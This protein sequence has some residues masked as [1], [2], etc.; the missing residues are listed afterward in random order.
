[1]QKDHV[2]WYSHRLGRDMGVAVYGHYGLPVLAFPTSGGEEWELE[3]M[4]LIPALAP[5]IDAGRVKFFVVGSNSR[6]SFYNAGAHPFHRSWMQ[7]MFDEYIRW[8]VIP[9]IH[10]RCKGLVHIATM[11][12]SLGALP[13]RQHDA[14]ASRRGE[15]VLGLVGRLRHAPFH[16]RRE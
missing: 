12:A 8:E 6:D 11:G 4:G 1:M 13:R 14:E 16:G 2:R 5:Y 3:N 7:R 9:F 15:G 10:D